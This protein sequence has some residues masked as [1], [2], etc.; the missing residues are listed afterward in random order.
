VDVYPL[1]A[2]LLKVPAAANDGNPDTFDAVLR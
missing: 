1:L 2:R